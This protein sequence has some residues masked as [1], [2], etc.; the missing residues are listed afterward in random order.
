MSSLA[1]TSTPPWPW[2]PRSIWSS[3]VLRSQGGAGL[4][5]VE[6]LKFESNWCTMPSF[7][8]AY[9]LFGY[10]WFASI[11]VMCLKKNTT[12][13]SFECD[14]AKHLQCRFA[15]PGNHKAHDLIH[16]NSATFRAGCSRLQ[17]LWQVYPY[18]FSAPNSFGL[19]FGNPLQMDGFPYQQIYWHQ[20]SGMVLISL[21]VPHV[22]DISS[23][24]GFVKKHKTPTVNHHHHQ[25]II[26]IIIIIL[27]PTKSFFMKL[28]CRPVFQ[29][30]TYCYGS[31]PFHPFCLRR[32]Q[33]PS[34]FVLALHAD[35]RRARRLG[36]PG[37][38]SVM[39]WRLG[40]CVPKKYA[41]TPQTYL[42]NA[43]FNS[44]YQYIP[45]C[46]M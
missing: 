16:L 4:R 1:A 43:A 20:H 26:I 46:I 37:K 27:I 41:T 45:I 40:R 44:I 8:Q 15:T 32:D 14:P 34:N 13:H 19:R 24:S 28:L 9:I 11:N 25:W 36:T 39:M 35:P 2:T 7:L 17:T 29:V 18:S 23:T 3:K 6:G 12:F 33:T 38:K 42:F 30:V 22:M 21:N 31:K 5:H 10:A